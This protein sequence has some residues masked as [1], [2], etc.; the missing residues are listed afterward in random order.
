MEARVPEMV[1]LLCE[2]TVGYVR[3]QVP[4]INEMN[5]PHFN[6]NVHYYYRVFK[7]P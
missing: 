3:T 5:R 7:A 4:T 6:G 2:S 1:S